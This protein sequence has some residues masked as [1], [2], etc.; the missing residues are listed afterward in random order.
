MRIII[1]FLFSICLFLTSYSKDLSSL[2]GK[3][4]IIPYSTI[5]DGSQ[6]HEDD[7]SIG[8]VYTSSALQNFNFKSK[9]LYHSTIWG[10]P[11]HVL[12]VETINKGKKDEAIVIVAMFNNEKVAIHIPF[13]YKADK[14]PYSARWFSN[15][16]REIGFSSVYQ[17]GRQRDL[18]FPYVETQTIDSIKS[19][20][21]NQ[22]VYPIKSSLRIKS[23]RRDFEINTTPSSYY[24]SQ[25][26]LLG[27]PY[28]FQDILLSE[29]YAFYHNSQCLLIKLKDM[30]GR[31][32]YF[33]IRCKTMESPF[34]FPIVSNDNHEEHTPFLDKL[35]DSFALE[36]DLIDLS[37]SESISTVLTEI[38]QRYL[39]K[40]IYFDTKIRDS[41]IEN[42]PSIYL[43][44]ENS[45]VRY[46]VAPKGFYTLAKIVKAPSDKHRPLLW[47]YAILQDSISR[48]AVP[49]NKSFLNFC[50]L[51]SEK[52]EYDLAEQLEEERL[53]QERE[54][55]Y[56][57]EE[58]EELNRLA[59]KY[60]SSNAKLIS[61]GEIR[62]GFSKAMV[63]EA[64]GSPGDIMTVSNALGTVECWIYGYSSYVYFKGNKVVQIIN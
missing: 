9:Y 31:I 46:G 6:Y 24:A 48:V 57:R 38:T 13:R 30:S 54:E 33:P 27:K 16:E 63:E 2:Q 52:R 23:D 59:R 50:Q 20:F 17:I 3:D 40:E 12:S 55:R 28:L 45:F 35:G 61:N 64:W 19:I 34:T 42:E 7:N 21:S 18:Y 37:Q 1:L 10:K 53:Q 36:N 44:D 5:H 58:R 56:A 14:K 49:I 32:S 22:I 11:I 60:G 41:Y 51:G 25:N 43:K 8:C 15:T 4:I 62:L 39:G 26:L 29:D 47:N